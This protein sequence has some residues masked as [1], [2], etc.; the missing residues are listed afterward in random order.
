MH[1]VSMTIDQL[2]ESL[3]VAKILDGH[4]TED[5][6][7]AIQGS[8]WACNR[9]QSEYIVDIKGTAEY[10]I[11]HDTKE[12]V[13]HMK[14]WPKLK[15][16]IEIVDSHEWHSSTRSL[17]TFV[18][19]FAEPDRFIVFVWLGSPNSVMADSP[20]ANG[21]CIDLL[22]FAQSETVRSIE[23]DIRVYTATRRS[24]RPS[25][26]SDIFGNFDPSTGSARTA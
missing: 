5:R 8:T 9:I 15:K 1:L 11:N 7:K 2:C 17:I 10:Q 20:L 26:I 23:H 22:G 25:F 12:F 16:L 24:I 21:W 6:L 4:T 19:S 14:D 3:G 13:I 18:R